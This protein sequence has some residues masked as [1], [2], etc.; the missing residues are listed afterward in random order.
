[1]PD[2]STRGSETCPLGEAC[3]LTIAWMAGAEK[4]K[5]KIKAQAAEIERLRGDLAKAVEALQGVRAFVGS[6]APYADQGH[7]LAP[8]LE[9]ACATLA[10][11]TGAKP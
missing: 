10:A 7:S 6:L 3:D 8:E 9:R 4:A 5:D 11:M 1:M 2:I